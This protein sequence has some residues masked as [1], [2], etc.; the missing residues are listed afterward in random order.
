LEKKKTDASHLSKLFRKRNFWMLTFR[1]KIAKA[2]WISDT[3]THS[4]HFRV[5]GYSS[6]CYFYKVPNIFI[7][8]VLQPIP[9]FLNDIN[10]QTMHTY[11]LC[12][13]IAISLKNLKCCRDSNLDLSQTCLLRTQNLGC[14]T[15]IHSFTTLIIICQ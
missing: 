8:I 1:L 6:N 9:S 11:Y 13:W 7:C 2:C 12:K 5:V 4:V 15:Y 3:V 10:T 14:R